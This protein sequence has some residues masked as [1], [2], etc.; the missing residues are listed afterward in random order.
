M[1]SQKSNAEL[2][3]SLHVSGRPLVLF[4]IWDVG[5]ARA[6]AASGASALATGSWSVA[7]AHGYEDGEQVPIEFALEN[8]MRIV[9]A[10]TLPVTIDLESGYS[11]DATGVGMVIAKAIAAGAIGC[12]LEDSNP[13]DGLMR[14]IPDQT[15]RL[16]HAQKAVGETGVPFFINARTDL[17]LQTPCDAHDEKLLDAALERGHNYAAAGASGLFVPGLIDLKLIRRAVVASAL[18][19]NIMMSGASPTH[20]QLA[21]AGVA[22]I[23]HGPGPF[24]MMMRQLEEVARQ[25]LT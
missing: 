22:R 8:I 12:N 2:F 1:I 15:E 9:G 13:A 21:D 7:S 18:P 6:V 4:N 25:A 20:A 3:R 19:I 10:T 5:S 16:K 23:S 24:R 11:A 17:F 14:T